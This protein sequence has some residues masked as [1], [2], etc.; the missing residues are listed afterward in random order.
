MARPPWR[1]VTFAISMTGSDEDGRSR[2]VVAPTGAIAN[3][4]DAG[5]AKRS[6]FA[7]QSGTASSRQVNATVKPLSLSRLKCPS[8]S[9]R[10]AVS[11]PE[12]GSSSK[13][14]VGCFN[15]PLAIRN[16]RCCPF[17]NFSNFKSSNSAR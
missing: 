17:D 3:R 16:R 1:T 5:A 8:S 4:F 6:T 7:T 11:S 2:T 15:N 9:A 10:V 13:S 12:N 14:S